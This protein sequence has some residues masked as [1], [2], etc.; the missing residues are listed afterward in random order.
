MINTFF[1]LLVSLSIPI[2]IMGFL[3]WFLSF[4]W[5]RTSNFFN[6]KIYNNYQK[7]HLNDISRFGGI[8]MYLFFWVIY[9]F[10][11]YENSFFINILIS[12]LPL[13]I[14]SFV[15]DIKHNTTPQIRLISMILS[16][17]IFFYINPINFPVISFPIFGELLMIFPVNYIFF[18]FTVLVVINGMNLVDGLNGLFGLTALCQLFSLGFLAYIY[19]DEELVQFISILSIPLI[20]FLFFNLILGKVF[21]GDLGAYVYGFIVSILTIYIF[22]KYN[23]LFTWLAILILF[24][25]CLELLFSFVRKVTNKFSP[26]EADKK[27]LHTILFFKLAEYFNNQKFTNPLAT[28]LLSLFWLLPSVLCILFNNTLIYIIFSIISLLVVYFLLY[29]YLTKKL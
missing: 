18:I 20:V 11:Y 5:N 7:I 16:C 6:L 17:L 26:F 23:T 2:F 22:G 8:C 14:I 15:E 12:S 9:S 4:H 13:A 1:S 27:H 28:L 25:P 10:D 3:L 29:K 19:F 24:Y 21:A